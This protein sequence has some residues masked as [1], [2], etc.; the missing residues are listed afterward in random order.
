M[1]LTV[2]LAACAMAGSACS[3][4]T[5]EPASAVP[6]AAQDSGYTSLALDDTFDDLASVDLTGTG[7]PGRRW[8]TDRPFGWGRTMPQD[9][10]VR[11]SVLTISP[12]TKSPNY[13]IATSSPTSHEGRGFRYGYFEARMAFDPEDWRRSTGW[14]AFWGLSHDQIVGVG[15][16]RWAELDF[17]EAYRDPG[18]PYE[19]IFAGTVHDWLAG[20]PETDRANHGNSS[21]PLAGVDLTQMHTYACL[22]QPG[23]ITWIFDGRELFTQTYSK[24]AAPSPNPRGLAP[25]I[26]SPLDTDVNGQ[27]VILG[28]GVDHPLRVDWVRVWQ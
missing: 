3:R 19:H 10:T 28:T 15:R 23:R 24:D 25:G 11:D 14:P 27:T 7:A 1:T 8:F 6:R 2:A 22:W 9:L 4:T 17:F 26:F 13:G 21:A 16:P 20:P 18:R 12:S 5:G